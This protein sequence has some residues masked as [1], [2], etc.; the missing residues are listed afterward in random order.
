MYN[1]VEP[2]LYGNSTGIS[3][4]AILVGA[5]FWAWLWGLVGLLL[6]T[7]LTVCLVV[8]G[9]HVPNLGFLRILLSDEPILSPP[10]R[11]YQRLLARDVREATGVAEAALKKQPLAEVFDGVFLPALGLAEA[12]RHHGRLKGEQ[13]QFVYNQMRMLV[14]QLAK[15]AADAPRLPA[16]RSGQPAPS[17]QD[18]EPKPEANGSRSVVCVP[19]WDEADELA[20]LMLARLLEQRGVSAEAL[21]RDSRSADGWHPADWDHSRLACVCAVPPFAYNQVRHLCRRLRQ[22]FQDVKLVAAFLNGQNKEDLQRRQPS[23]PA[24]ELAVNLSQALDAILPLLD[25][26]AQVDKPAAGS[27]AA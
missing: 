20:A 14:T 6:A 22:E 2:L 27:A 3:P 7:P 5:L 1:F 17:N 25:S 26:G 18:P 16:S 8:L 23:I 15:R 21:P 10:T 12:D 11:F 13:Q 4:L 24:Q 9:R 19:A